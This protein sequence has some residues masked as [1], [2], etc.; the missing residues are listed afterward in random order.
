MDSVEVCEV[1]LWNKPQHEERP[2]DWAVIHCTNNKKWGGAV[3]IVV[4]DN[5][6]ES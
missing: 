6:L 1:Y 2:H 4:D 5:I 3:K